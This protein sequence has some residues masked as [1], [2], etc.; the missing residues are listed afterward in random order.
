MSN[1]Q[2]KGNEVNDNGVLHVEDY[3]ESIDAEFI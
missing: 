3:D 2:I 1:L